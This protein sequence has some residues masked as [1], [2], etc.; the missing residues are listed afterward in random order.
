MTSV[1][2]TLED[3]P[4]LV[5]SAPPAQETAPHAMSLAVWAVPETVV[6]GERFGIKI[7]AKSSAD[8]ALAGCRI[9]VLDGAGAVVASGSLGETPW[10][11]TGALFWTDVTL[12]APAT[13]GLLALQARFEAAAL[14]PP[15]DGAS[16]P[17]RVAVVARPEHVLTVKVSA[18]GIPVEE[19]YVRLGPH[20]AVTDAAGT[21]K[22]KLAPG[23]YALT[24]WKAGYDAPSTPVEI[25][26][27]AFVAVE[28]RALPEED[29][30][31]HWTG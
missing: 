2:A 5:A 13:P 27:D 29:P 17:F 31:A 6:A 1:N 19:A 16:A 26:A 23:T 10:P 11:G 30:D 20:R 15:H 8:C 7:G 24:V 18:A 9:E 21:A 25:G 3:A 14:D 22:L 4:A 28:A 12:D